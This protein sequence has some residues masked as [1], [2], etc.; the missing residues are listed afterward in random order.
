MVAYVSGK[1][2]AKLQTEQN[3]LEIKLDEIAKKY[4]TS[5]E[6]A[7]DPEYG[8]TLDAIRTIQ[9]ELD[10][11]ER[12]AVK[13]GDDATEPQSESGDEQTQTVVLRRADGDLVFKGSPSDCDVVSK[14]IDAAAKNAAAT[15]EMFYRAQLGE[16]LSAVAVMP[17]AS[18]NTDP[19]ELSVRLPRLFGLLATRF[20]GD[21]SARKTAQ[22]SLAQTLGAFAGDE[23]T[24]REPD[25]CANQPTTK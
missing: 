6:A 25:E 9:N 17:V 16:F 20:F 22:T 10:V 23:T 4:A 2:K 11:V 19:V 14:M 7:A 18:K 21:E 12:L 1:Y 13:Y 8:S 5:E 24:E 15:S 3:E